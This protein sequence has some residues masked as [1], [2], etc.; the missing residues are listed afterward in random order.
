MTIWPRA[1]FPTLRPTFVTSSLGPVSLE[2]SYLRELRPL[3][4]LSHQGSKWEAAY[5]ANFPKAVYLCHSTLGSL[6]RSIDPRC[7]SRIDISDAGQQL[8]WTSRE[9]NT[10]PVPFPCSY[11]SKHA[12]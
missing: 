4:H 7:M 12:E 10:L 5:L 6:R 11:R 1:D 2:V 8:L 3:S 9:L